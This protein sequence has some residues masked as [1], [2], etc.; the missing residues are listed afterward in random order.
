MTGGNM[1]HKL[2]IILILFGC[3]AVI[4]VGAQDKSKCIST[5]ETH[6][7]LTRAQ[8]QCN[9]KDYSA[10][11]M[12]S[13]QECYPVLGE[14]EAKDALK[15]GMEMFDYNE[16]KRGRDKICKDVLHDFPNIFHSEEA[17]KVEPP[18]EI[19]KPKPK[20]PIMDKQRKHDFALCFNFAM[21]QHRASIYKDM[22]SS[23]METH[24]KMVD[25]LDQYLSE[26]KAHGKEPDATWEEYEGVLR[27]AIKQ[28]YADP[29][30]TVELGRT[31]QFELIKDCTNK[32]VNN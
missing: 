30:Y 4:S 22:G 3:F 18:V 14:K 9:I 1:K 10:D 23:A 27:S 13:A 7:F 16:G 11:M 17:A 32:H 12:Q 8:F 21:N 31:K 29:N 25:E 19:A 26:S 6:G 20:P 28:V 15:S 24:E 5:I 2:T